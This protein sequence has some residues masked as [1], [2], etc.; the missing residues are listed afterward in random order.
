MGKESKERAIE[1]LVKVMSIYD[2]TH[3]SSGCEEWET[4][5]AAHPE[6][7]IPSSWSIED[8]RAASNSERETRAAKAIETICKGIKDR[9][10]DCADCHS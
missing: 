9:G 5:I 2:F 8:V 6:A 7:V 10:N 1:E 3:L 4:Y